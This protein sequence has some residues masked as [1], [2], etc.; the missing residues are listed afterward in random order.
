MAADST[1]RAGRSRRRRWRRRAS[2][3]W[4]STSA[5]TASPGVPASPILSA[6]RCTST[7]S[8]RPRAAKAR[9]EDRVDRRGKHGGHRRGRA[10]IE[11]EPG[12]IDRLVFLGS[13]GS[14]SHP[15]KMKGR[16]LF[17]VARDDLGPSD[18]PRL[19]KNSRGLRKNAGAEGTHHPRRIGP[20]AVPL[21]FRPGRAHNARDPA[22]PFRKVGWTRRVERTRPMPIDVSLVPPEETLRLRDLKFRFRTFWRRFAS[23]PAGIFRR[24]V[25]S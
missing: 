14:D 3:S 2:V 7:C 13:E 4:R 25:A 11:A 19:P 9:C 8:R 20:R 16:K 18:I 1:R 23:G 22:V 10:S 6:R 17:I 12:E 21:Q 15:E 24:P 5:D